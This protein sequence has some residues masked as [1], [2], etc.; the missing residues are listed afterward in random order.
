MARPV[1]QGDGTTVLRP[2]LEEY[3]EIV[4]AIVKEHFKSHPLEV[5]T[6]D[7]KRLDALNAGNIARSFRESMPEETTERKIVAGILMV[8]AAMRLDETLPTRFAN[9]AR[10]KE[11]GSKKAD[12]IRIYEECI[13]DTD[14]NQ[15]E[16]EREIM[17]KLEIGERTVQGYLKGIPRRRDRK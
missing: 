14:W 15:G 4:E 17:T 3:L 12:A 9:V 16:I 10:Q 5:G 6:K 11:A 13:N 8:L 2:V 7:P 1:D